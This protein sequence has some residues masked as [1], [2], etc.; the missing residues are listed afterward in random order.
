MVKNDGQRGFALLIAIG[1][2]ALI[3][4]AVMLVGRHL[5]IRYDEYRL[6][7]RDVHLVA[8]S[9]SAVAETLASLAADSGFPG[10]PSRPFGGGTVGSRVVPNGADSVTVEARG[11]YAGWMMTIRAEV[12]LSASGP[13]VMQWKRGTQPTS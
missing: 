11:T 4:A 1:A 8:L 7:K 12:S 5:Q 3:A 9:D 2:T 10:I 13:R 6:D